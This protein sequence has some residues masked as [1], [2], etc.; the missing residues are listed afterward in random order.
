MNTAQRI[1]KGLKHNYRLEPN[2]LYCWEAWRI[3][4]ESGEALPDFARQYFDRVAASFATMQNP[5]LK[6]LD[7]NVAKA[8]EFKTPG[9]GTP[10]TKAQ[11][12][13]NLDGY[14]KP[15]KPMVYAEIQALNKA[16]GVPIDVA[17]RDVAETYSLSESAARKYYYEM[18]PNTK[19][20]NKPA[21]HKGTV[22]K[23]KY[24][25]RLSLEHSTCNLMK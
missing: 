14:N 19:A 25:K 2:S 20:G 6:R 15:G 12:M 16:F 13:G 21:F 7:S 9:S 17:I 18:K 3:S 22:S 5:E 1:L 8:T 24:W 23:W 10:F 4:S 11:K